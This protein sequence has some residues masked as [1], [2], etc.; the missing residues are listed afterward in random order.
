M[1]FQS[2]GVPFNYKPVSYTHLDVY[3]R[4]G[5]IQLEIG[6]QS[7]NDATITEIHRTM[8]L[9]RLKAVV[10]SIQEKMC[11]RDRSYSWV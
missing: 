5:L 2:P 7:T 9:D 1:S 6:V 8:Q 4:Q 11:I 3:K 10:R